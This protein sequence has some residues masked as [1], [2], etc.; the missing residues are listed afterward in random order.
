M[1]SNKSRDTRPEIA[2]RR[3]LFRA[4]H[5]YRKHYFP[6]PRSRNEVDIAFPGIRLAIFVDGCFWHGCVDHRSIRPKANAT[7]WARKLDANIERDRETTAAL[8]SSGWTVIR[9]WEHES[10]DDAV[11]LI[12]Q[13][14]RS[15]SRR[16]EAPTSG[17][18]RSAMLSARLRTDSR[19]AE[20]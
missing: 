1:R 6:W 14:I 18:T 7:Y 19:P 8:V 9:I 5:R 15:L 4:G 11:T 2:L 16:L 13:A 10:T 20:P 17:S 3:E 12:G